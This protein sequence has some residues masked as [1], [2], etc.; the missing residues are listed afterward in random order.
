M[1]RAIFSFVI[2]TTVIAGASAVA[3]PSCPASLKGSKIPS[4][5]WNDRSTKPGY[6]APDSAVINDGNGHVVDGAASY[7]TVKNEMGSA[8][9][10]ATFSLVG[11]VGTASNLPAGVYTCSY[12]G[13]RFRKG[14]ET[15]QATVTVACTNS[16]APL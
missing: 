11:G 14:S 9:A 4:T 5:A 15:L 10:G 3:G 8:F 16:C 6:Y 7:D 1:N 12:D 13:P 2:A